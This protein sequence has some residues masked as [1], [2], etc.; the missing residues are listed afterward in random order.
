MS[1]YT[2][3]MGGR[4]WLGALARGRWWVSVLAV[5]LGAGVL[6]AA[7][8]G[9]TDSDPR[10]VAVPPPRADVGVQV[11]AKALAQPINP[12]FVGLSLE[13]PA[14][15]A[16]SGADPGAINPVFVQLIRN[17]APNQR[18]V[19]RIGGDS[20]DSTWWPVT[21]GVRPAGVSYTLSPLWLT[22]TR[23]LARSL[24]ARLI[25]GVNL[26]VAQPTLALAEAR[27]FLAG[28]GR[29]TV[30]ALEI[31]N[32]VNRYSTFPYYHA[33]P[34]H[35]VFGRPSGYDFGDFTAEFSA[36]R[37]LL[38][39]VPLAGPTVGG[40]Q[41]LAPLRSFL[42]AEPSVRLVTFHRYPLDRCFSTK[43]S[44]LYPSVSALLSTRTSRGLAAGLA[45][46]VA[47]AHSRG[48]I[49][50]VDEMQSVACGGKRGVSNT[51]ASAL[52][53]LNAL[54]SM[55]AQ[56]VDGVNVHTFPGAS[57]GLFTFRRTGEQWSA[58]VRPEY[59]GLALFAQAAPAGSRLLAVRTLGPAAVRA[60]A[61]RGADGH[62]RVLLLNDDPRRGHVVA[63]SAPGVT[64][65]ATTERLTAPSAW[66][67][68]GVTLGGRRFDPLT[69]AL[70]GPHRALRVPPYAG[71][72]T[73]VLPAASAALVTLPATS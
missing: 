8:T 21:G 18:P 56:G 35:P 3:E 47:I 26:E 73:V 1:S 22:N 23:A 45:R 19:I 51:F 29:P 70:S 5:L 7:V 48:A 12:G 40:F 17:L 37:K 10:A 62:L 34:H 61:T 9:L 67:T 39:P 63:V 36:L 52:W 72:H 58:S 20:T 32:E 4:G 24:D 11:E 16:Y 71:R 46:Y 57:Y 33:A 27:A 38:P 41:W 14:V 49:F 6:T 69:G 65:D 44:P 15:L 55:A 66:A 30:E 28:I 64:G 2:K 53:A 60:W 43:G 25:L 31:G 59:Y 13:Y 54:F 68:S 50:R 42:A